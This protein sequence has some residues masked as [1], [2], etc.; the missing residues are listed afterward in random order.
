[1]SSQVELW[2]KHPDYAGIEV[3]TFGNVRTL[4]RLV[5]SEKYTRFTKGRVLK[6]SNDKDGYLQVRILIDGK[7]TTKKV[8]R[9]TAQTFIKNTDNLPQ[10]NHKNCVRDD[11]RVSNLEWCTASY[12]SRYREKHG[13]SQMEALGK[14][15]FAI[16]LTTLEVSR[17]RS[18]SEAS[19]SLGVFVS[20]INAV[21][22]G[23]YKQTHGYLFIN[24]DG[25]AVDVVKS[26]LHNIGKTGLK[27]KC[28]AV[29]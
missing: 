4:D 17:F 20:N 28:R 14:P 16:N 29:H 23:K 21:I 2:K 15:V 6:Q 8:H 5:S 12:N 9:L 1:M 11:N 7:W 24:D 10:V 27:I 18:Q 25:H 13:V 19:G 22:N 26:N 3:S